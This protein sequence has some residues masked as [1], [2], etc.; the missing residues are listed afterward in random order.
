MYQGAGEPG[1]TIV[2]PTYTKYHWEPPAD[3]KYTFDLDKAGQLLDE[4]GYKMGS[5]G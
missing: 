3:Q 5:D 4:A 2:P 1:T